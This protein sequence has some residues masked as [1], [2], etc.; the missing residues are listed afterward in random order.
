SGLNPQASNEFS[1]LI[2]G[3]ARDGAAILMATHDLFRAKETG[4]RIGIM[5]HGRLRAEFAAADVSHTALE[6]AYLDHMRD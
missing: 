6:Q 4:T 1:K 5:R 2:L 3:L